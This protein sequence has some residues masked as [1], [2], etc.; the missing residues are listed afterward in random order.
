M[1]VK[2]VKTKEVD[3][4]E[5][6]SFVSQNDNAALFL[7]SE[8]VVMPRWGSDFAG[9]KD[10]VKKATCSQEY[11]RRMYAVAIES[12]KAQMRMHAKRHIISDAHAS[13][14]MKVLMKIKKEISEGKVAFDPSMQDIYEVIQNRVE[15]VLGKEVADQMLVARSKSDQ[16]AGDLRIWIRD[17][18]DGLDASLQ[19]LQSV[20]LDKAEENV[21]TI[22]PGFSNSQLTQPISFGH[23]LMSYVEM[24]TRDR[25][26]IKDARVRL[27]ESPYGSGDIGGSEFNL[28]RD[29][30]ARLL[31]FEGP[32][33]NS[34]DSV[35][36]R[37][38]VVE[39]LSCASMVSMHLSRLAEDIISMHA[40]DNS[41]LSFS[42]DLITQHDVLPFRRDPE[43]LEVVRGRTGSVYGALMNVLTVLKGLPTQFCHDLTM[44][45]QPVFDVYDV[46]SNS[47]DVVSAFVADC[48]INKRKLKEVATRSYSTAT[49]LMNW[50]M[51]NLGIP[52][53]RA[54]DLTRTIIEYSISK[55]KKLSLLSLEELQEI[56]PRITND[57]Y[58]VL[59][60]SRAMISRRSGN[61]TNPVQIRKAIRFARRASL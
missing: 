50:M 12:I 44:V 20:L 21:K 59:I 52:L 22:M 43:A 14:I 11:D 40:N 15:E 56:E 2:N 51:I 19:N 42:N 33:K 5:E 49:D 41:F 25:S 23:Y 9:K 18:Y 3:N 7:D 4:M 36:S 32:T 39:F 46:V 10:S 61:G 37:D 28:N 6:E 27:N 1:A 58:S 29:S 31:G 60:P 55:N 8:E 24:L 53:A 48:L 57:V 54:E 38:F 17:A 30:V 34:I 47:A 26:R 16:V 45:S 35:A 13:E